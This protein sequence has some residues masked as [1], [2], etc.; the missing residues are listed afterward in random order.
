VAK[1]LAVPVL[2][3]AEAAG[4]LRLPDRIVEV[5]P[6]TVAD[7]PGPRRFYRWSFPAAEG[8]RLNPEADRG[9]RT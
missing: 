1:S 5:S 4:A 3:T 8:L 9:V 2:L 6:Q 7:F